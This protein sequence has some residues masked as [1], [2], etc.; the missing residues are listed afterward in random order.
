MSPGAAPPPVQY[1]PCSHIAQ[2]DMASVDLA[3]A[4]SPAAQSASVHEDTPLLLDALNFP[5][6]Q[7]LHEVDDDSALL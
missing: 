2:S 1:L 5:M 7:S 6:G 3:G 4:Y